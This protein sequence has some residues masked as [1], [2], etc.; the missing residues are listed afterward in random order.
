MGGGCGLVA[1]HPNL[2]ALDLRTAM[3]VLARGVLHRSIRS[4]DPARHWFVLWPVIPEPVLYFRFDRSAFELQ[5][6]AA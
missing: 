2:E 6:C 4:P 3:L 1:A 5:A